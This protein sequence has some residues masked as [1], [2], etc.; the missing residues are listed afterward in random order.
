MH[1]TIAAGE[2][3]APGKLAFCGSTGYVGDRNSGRVLANG[4]AD[5]PIDVRALH[6][7]DLD[8]WSDDRQSQPFRSLCKALESKL[9]EGTTFQF[10]LPLIENVV[11]SPMSGDRGVWERTQ[12]AAPPKET[13]VVLCEDRFVARE[14]RLARGP[15]RRPGGRFSERRAFR[16]QHHRW[17]ARKIAARLH[18]AEHVDAH[19]RGAHAA[20][21]A[22]T[23]FSIYVVASRG[24]SGRSGPHLRGMEEFL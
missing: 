2:N 13:L 21:R 9:G 10:T 14:H 8:G 5:L 24:G 15:R 11:A 3:H 23:G 7:T 6:T 12:R 16:F 4:E 17:P 18:V 22:K 19:Y 1:P 20:S